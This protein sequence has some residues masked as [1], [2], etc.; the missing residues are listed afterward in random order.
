VA[1]RYATAAGSSRLETWSV[2]IA[3]YGEFKG[4]RLPVRIVVPGDDVLG[5]KHRDHPR[6]GLAVAL[7]DDRP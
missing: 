3:E 7:P 2:P 1:K 5:C 4:L 6:L